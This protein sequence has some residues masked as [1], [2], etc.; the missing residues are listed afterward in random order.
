MV[1]RS[2]ARFVFP[3]DSTKSYSWNVPAPNATGGEPLFAWEASWRIPETPSTRDSPFGVVLV[4]R[5]KASG[6]ARG[7][8]SKLIRNDP[9]QTQFPCHGCGLVYFARTDSDLF[10]SVEEGRL[11]FTIRGSAA[12]RRILP[13]VPDSVQFTYRVGNAEIYRA[14]S[15]VNGNR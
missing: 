9:L 14:V 5:W 11:V 2:E 7:P 3:Y 15:V 4:V 8:L 13:I 10:A 1:G 12:I 6:E